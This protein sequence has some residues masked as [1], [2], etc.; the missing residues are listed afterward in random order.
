MRA[1]GPYLAFV[2]PHEKSEGSLSYCSKSSDEEE[3]ELKE[4]FKVLFVKFLKLRE[5]RQQHL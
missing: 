2:A 4:G 3:E 1:S 5:T